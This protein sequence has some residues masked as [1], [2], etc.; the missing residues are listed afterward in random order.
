[1][2]LPRRLQRMSARQIEA[3]GAGRGS[4]ELSFLLAEYQTLRAE[5]L[6]ADAE[7]YRVLGLGFAGVIACL[8]AG[9]RVES[10]LLGA[11]IA[12]GAGVCT[13]ALRFMLEAG[14]RRIWRI[15]TYLRVCLEPAT[16][17][18]R[19]ES[20]L[21]RLPGRKQSR[22]SSLAIQRE[23]IIVCV[24]FMACGV[25][26]MLRI[27][28]LAW[29]WWVVLGLQAIFVVHA[30][31]LAWGAARAA[32]QLRRG[33]RVEKECAK[34]WQRL[35]DSERASQHDATDPSVAPVQDAR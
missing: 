13:L 8:W 20:R 29:P 9:L 34:S 18:L 16:P 3:E 31:W 15:S 17:A 27:A 10:D 12:F 14:R 21:S 23:G 7:N 19:W 28:M 22:L 11:T 30:C 1:M 24:L 32:A 35:V 6:Q 26:G 5:I 4:P 33:G 2:P 25:V